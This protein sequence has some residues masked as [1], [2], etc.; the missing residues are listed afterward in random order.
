MQIKDVHFIHRAHGGNT[1]PTCAGGNG[2]AVAIGPWQTGTLKKWWLPKHIPSKWTIA[3]SFV[4][5][6]E[7]IFLQ[8]LYVAITCLSISWGW[9]GRFPKK[10]ARQLQPPVRS[11][12]DQH[13]TKWNLTHVPQIQIQH[14]QCLFSFELK[15]VAGY[16]EKY[17]FDRL[18]ML[19]RLALKTSIERI[20]FKSQDAHC[21]YMGG[22]TT[23]ANIEIGLF[24]LANWGY[25]TFGKNTVDASSV[26]SLSLSLQTIEGSELVKNRASKSLIW[27]SCVNKWCLMVPGQDE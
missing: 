1:R 10:T 14:L 26:N 21:V 8:L 25:L 19:W 3:I 7:W 16:Q 13:G 9:K 24:W 20:N 18:G 2:T 15:Q 17:Y 22:T 6:S 27:A 11:I 23:L 12:K 5:F 4:S